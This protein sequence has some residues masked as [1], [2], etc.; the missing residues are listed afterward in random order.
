MSTRERWKSLSLAAQRRIAA[1]LAAQVSRQPRYTAR[2]MVR[3]QM[4]LHAF[5]A[6]DQWPEEIERMRDHLGSAID[7]CHGTRVWALRSQLEVIGSLRRTPPPQL[8]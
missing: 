3:R 7:R 5:L 6:P 1:S 2:L 4:A 8:P